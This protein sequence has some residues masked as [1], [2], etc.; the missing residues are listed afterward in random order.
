MERSSFPFGNEG[1]LVLWKDRKENVKQPRTSMLIKCILVVGIISLLLFQLSLQRQFSFMLEDMDYMTNLATGEELT[2]IGD[3]LQSMKEAFLYKG[4]GLLSGAVLQVQLLLGEAMADVANVVALLAIAVLVCLAISAK[5]QRF[6][7]V[8]LPLFLLI[9]FNDDW[10]YS[11]CWQFGMT[12]FVYPAIPFLILLGMLIRGADHPKS[13]FEEYFIYL[14]PVLA[15]L[16]GIYNGGYGLV[17]CAMTALLIHLYK[18][19]LGR[20][21]PGWMSVSLLTSLVGSLIFSFIPG[22]FT[23]FSV[24]KDEQLT[25]HIFPAIV[26]MLFMLAILMRA[27]GW[28]SVSQIMMLGGLGFSVVLRFIFEVT[29]FCGSNGIRICTIVLAITLCCS[30][31]YRMNRLN[32]WFRFYGYMMA[33]CSWVYAMLIM[34]ENYLGVM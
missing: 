9:S 13:R 27:G 17:I 22:N 3:I 31:I 16:L 7:F 11:Y 8:A 20:K 23:A 6:F 30:L 28:L 32:S 10:Q 29:P 5:H 19:L 2:G 26:F 21:I 4:G 15:F 33:L 34:A 24:I 18:S 12:Q 1:L 14:G 25:L